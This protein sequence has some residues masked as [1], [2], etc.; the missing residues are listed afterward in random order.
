METLNEIFPG[1]IP[2][3]YQTNDQHSNEFKIYRLYCFE[4]SI[5]IDLKFHLEYLFQQSVYAIKNFK[6]SKNRHRCFMQFASS[7][8]DEGIDSAIGFSKK[9]ELSLIWDIWEN[10]LDHY[11]EKLELLSIQRSPMRIRYAVDDNLWSEAAIELGTSLIPVFKL[12]RLFFKK[13][14]RQRI[15]QEVKLF[16]EMCSDQ[17]Y[18]LD[19]STDDIRKSLCSMLY[20]IEDPDHIDPLET[21]LA[22]MEG[23]K[24]LVT[25]FESY[26]CLIN[27]HI[28]PTLFPVDTDFTS[29]VY[30]QN[31]YITWTTSF[32]LATDNSIQIAQ[33]FGE[34]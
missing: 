29:Y 11:D 17:L 16:T 2:E 24:Q 9:S 18:W 6:R 1:R 4:S 14:Y 31:W 33:S 15:K 5:R 3:P 28:I 22:I 30:F 32:L 21:R 13:L 25:Y 7:F 10:A 8:T 27:G 19:R 20:S 26:L 34:T 23:V 12:I